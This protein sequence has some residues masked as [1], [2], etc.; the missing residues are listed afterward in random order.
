MR[1]GFGKGTDADGNVVGERLSQMISFTRSGTFSRV[2]SKIV[3]TQVLELL[4]PTTWK[5]GTRKSGGY[6]PAQREHSAKK[7]SA[8][9]LGR[10]NVCNCNKHVIYPDGNNIQFLRHNPEGLRVRAAK[11]RMEKL[12]GLL[13]RSRTEFLA[14]QIEYGKD[15]IRSCNKEIRFVKC[16]LPK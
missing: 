16:R 8:P 11:M 7:V 14:G 6:S 15:S 10:E 2:R 3:A 1:L 13:G 9:F 5:F 4:V 12:F